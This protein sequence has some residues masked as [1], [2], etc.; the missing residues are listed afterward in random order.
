[1]ITMMTRLPNDGLGVFDNSTYKNRTLL[2]IIPPYAICH[3]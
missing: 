2:A 3:F 1:M